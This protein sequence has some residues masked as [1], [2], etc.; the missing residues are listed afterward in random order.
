M[1]RIH[2][3]SGEWSEGSDPYS[4]RGWTGMPQPRDAKTV[5]HVITDVQR[6]L[7]IRAEFGDNPGCPMNSPADIRRLIAP[8]ARRRGR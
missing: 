3:T 5:A 4:C 7:T 1:T 2:F 6:E 8:D